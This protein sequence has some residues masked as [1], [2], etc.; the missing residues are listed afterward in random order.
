MFIAKVIGNVWATRKHKALEGRK[1]LIVQPVNSLSR[2]PEGQPQMAVEEG[3]GAGPGDTVLVLD[4]GSS[5]RQILGMGK[6]PLRT[7]VAGVVDEVFCGGK[8]KKYH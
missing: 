3:I 4:E 6:G 1:L 2:R 7:I 5:C 8:K